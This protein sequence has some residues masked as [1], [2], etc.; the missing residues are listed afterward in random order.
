MTQAPATTIATAVR[1]HGGG[2]HPLNLPSTAP[3]G[4]LHDSRGGVIN[5]RAEGATTSHPLP[6]SCAAA[7]H[8]TTG[9]RRARELSP[10]LRSQNRPHAQLVEG[11]TTS[12]EALTN[13]PWKKL[14]KFFPI[15]LELCK[16]FHN[17]ALQVFCWIRS[18]I[19]REQSN[20][21]GQ[22]IAV[23]RSDDVALR[24]LIIIKVQHGALHNPLEEI[25]ICSLYCNPLPIFFALAPLKAEGLRS[26]IRSHSAL[27][28]SEQIL[29]GV[30]CLPHKH[31]KPHRMR[32]VSYL[33]IFSTTLQLLLITVERDDYRNHDGKDGANCLDPSRRILQASSSHD[34]LNC[35]AQSS[36]CQESPNDPD[37]SNRHPLGDLPLT[38]SNPLQQD[39]HLSLPALC[40]HVQRGAA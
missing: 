10:S 34:H 9:V 17:P 5:R 11:Y 2:R 25:Y 13:Q 31:M 6:A 8:P 38:H 33:C 7:A 24:I 14:Q 12:F 26:Y 1:Q 27:R 18:Y 20:Q 35:P 37:G 23:L 16:S 40:H 39:D 29:G 21:N 32:V 3:A 30:D 19:H 36:Y 4:R 15:T 28:S 22:V